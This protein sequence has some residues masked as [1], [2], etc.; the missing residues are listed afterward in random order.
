VQPR[1]VACSLAL[2]LER[3]RPLAQQP[4]LAWGELVAVRG[5]VGGLDGEQ[6]FD[7]LSKPYVEACEVA[8]GQQ[9]MLAVIV[10]LTELVGLQEHPNQRVCTEAR[11][12]VRGR[13]DCER[14][15]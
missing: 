3:Q 5:E 8:V 6:L 1:E 7:V 2:H 4:Y 13:G 15:V 10:C 9:P 11:P 12:V 14:A